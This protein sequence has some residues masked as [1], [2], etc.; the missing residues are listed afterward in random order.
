MPVSKGKVVGL[1]FVS[2]DF[3][4]GEHYAAY[5]KVREFQQKILTSFYSLSG[6]IL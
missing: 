4:F 3:A 5:F 6:L 1:L 2:I